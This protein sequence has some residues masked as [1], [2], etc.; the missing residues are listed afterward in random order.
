MTSGGF[1][2]SLKWNSSQIFLIS[3]PV[4]YIK[5]GLSY[6]SLAFTISSIIG[7]C[8]LSQVI[9]KGYQKSK[10]FNSYLKDN[11]AHVK[12]N[13]CISSYRTVYSEQASPPHANAAY[14]MSRQTE[15]LVNQQTITS[16]RSLSFLY[17]I[18]VIWRLSDFFA[19]DS[20]SRFIVH[21]PL[22]TVRFTSH[23]VQHRSSLFLFKRKQREEWEPTI[24]TQYT[25]CTDPKF[26]SYLT[27]F[28]FSDLVA[29]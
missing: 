18:N 22:F 23:N 27:H 2:F 15:I 24:Q 29:L 7:S 21:F 20:P 6:L 12:I 19:L 28:T 25:S 14:L 26:F 4:T 3:L 5:S 17:P 11:P 1:T 13:L 16:L 9:L 10:A 8:L